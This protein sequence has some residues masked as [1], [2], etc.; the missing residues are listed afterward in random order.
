MFEMAPSGYR[1]E[2]GESGETGECKA[3]VGGKSVR[4]GGPGG[5]GL[6]LRGGKVKF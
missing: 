5:G 3:R 2:S 4:D 1:V 6:A